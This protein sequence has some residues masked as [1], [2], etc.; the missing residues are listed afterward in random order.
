M[1]VCIGVL[2]EDISRWQ[3]SYFSASIEVAM[4]MFFDNIKPAQAMQRY[5]HTTITGV[6]MVGD[7]SAAAGRVNMRIHFIC[8]AG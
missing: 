3:V 5:Q 7:F 8:L 4:V 6:F 2:I 1:F